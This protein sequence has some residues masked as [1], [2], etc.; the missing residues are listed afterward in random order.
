MTCVPR[1]TDGYSSLFIVP[2]LSNNSGSQKA[3][4]NSW[5]NYREP[6]DDNGVVRMT[7]SEDCPICRVRCQP[8]LEQ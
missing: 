4:R 8:C 3:R 6:F 5:C 1:V 7:A 2:L